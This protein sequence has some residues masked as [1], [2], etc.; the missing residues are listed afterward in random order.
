MKFGDFLPIIKENMKAFD[1]IIITVI[2]KKWGTNEIIFS[3][4]QDIDR[5]FKFFNNYLA[6]ETIVRM[7]CEKIK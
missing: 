2:S 6:Q 4:N 3:R 5:K 7:S 1:Y